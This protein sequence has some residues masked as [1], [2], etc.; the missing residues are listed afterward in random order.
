MNTTHIDKHF[1]EARRQKGLAYKLCWILG[2]GWMSSSTWVDLGS[3]LNTF[4]RLL[5][6]SMHIE[7]RSKWIYCKAQIILGKSKEWKKWFLK[8]LKT[9][10]RIQDSQKQYSGF[11]RIHDSA[12]SMQH[13]ACRI[14][15]GGCRIQDSCSRIQNWRFRIQDLQKQDSGFRMQDSGFRIYHHMV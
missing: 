10:F 5:C 4:K 6:W 13:A 14:P 15:H 9:E 1:C 2:G 3:S 7:P 11:I 12:C 8:N